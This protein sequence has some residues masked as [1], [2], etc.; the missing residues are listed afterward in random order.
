[1][2]VLVLVKERR[3]TDRRLQWNAARMWSR[4][5][6]KVWDGVWGGVR[7]GVRMKWS[8]RWVS[9]M[10]YAR[11]ARCAVSTGLLLLLLQ[12]GRACSGG[13]LCVRGSTSGNRLV[14]GTSGHTLTIHKSYAYYSYTH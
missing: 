6:G 9:W 10:W 4:V 1:M 5:W 3:V 14:G 7:G 11:V 12:Q 8:T 2:V 13:R